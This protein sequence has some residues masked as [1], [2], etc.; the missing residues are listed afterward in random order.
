MIRYETQIKKSK[1]D[2]TQ[3]TFI[4]T[5]SI[6]IMGSPGS[7]KTI[8][9]KNCFEAIRA[10]TKVKT[11][12]INCSNSSLTWKVDEV[13]KNKISK[14]AA[15]EESST[16]IEILDVSWQDIEFEGRT[17]E[18]PTKVIGRLMEKIIKFVEKSDIPC[19]IIIEEIWMFEPQKTK[20]LMQLLNV[21]VQRGGYFIFTSLD[22]CRSLLL[23]YSLGTK[24]EGIGFT[25]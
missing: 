13:V 6:G 1:I 19:V 9:L 21:V 16:D 20:G 5:H 24:R 3:K 14:D 15:L 23:L 8:M 25:C 7:G 4:G 18:V 11:I 17:V 2:M 22:S 10:N 12:S